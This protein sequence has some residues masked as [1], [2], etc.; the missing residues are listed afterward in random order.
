MSKCLCK[1]C[2]YCIE[3]V[4]GDEESFFGHAYA[5]NVSYEMECKKGYYKKFDLE[6]ETN[7]KGFKTRE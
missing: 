2:K 3:E 4:Y 6:K 1:D 5:S 7:C